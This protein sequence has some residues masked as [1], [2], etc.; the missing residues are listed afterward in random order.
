MTANERTVEHRIDYK[1]PFKIVDEC[2]ERKSTK[3]IRRCVD[4]KYNK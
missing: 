4:M 1:K 2:K 3:D